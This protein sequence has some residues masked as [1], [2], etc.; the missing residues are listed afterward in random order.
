MSTGILLSVVGKD[1]RTGKPTLPQSQGQWPPVRP[2]L[3]ELVYRSTKS[4]QDLLCPVEILF[5]G[6]VF[7]LGIMMWIAG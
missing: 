4:S 7:K 5:K 3:I 2:V 1:F 6:F